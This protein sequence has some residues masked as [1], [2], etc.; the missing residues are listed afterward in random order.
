[1]GVATTYNAGA[2]ICSVNGSTVYN[3]PAPG[4]SISQTNKQL[5]TIQPHHR[6]PKLIHLGIVYLVCQLLSGCVNTSQPSP[7][8][9]SADPAQM[10]IRALLLPAGEP[11]AQAL[12][13]AATAAPATER[14]RLEL[15]A[16]EQW[17]Q[18]GRIETASALVNRLDF[19]TDSDSWLLRRQMLVAQ[20][21]LI[22]D[23]LIGA[24][25]ALNFINQLSVSPQERA[26]ALQLLNSF[27]RSALSF[28]SL[29]ATL[30]TE[31][32]L[33]SSVAQQRQLQS[34]LLAELLR[35]PRS[36]LDTSINDNFGLDAR[37]W[38]E[39]IQAARSQL[40]PLERSALLNE[41]QRRY[42]TVQVDPELLA[43]L[44]D[45]NPMASELP[46]KIALLLPYTGKLANAGKAL[47]DGIMAAYFASPYAMA[48][49]EL[50]SY[51]TGNATDVAEIYQRAVSEG[52]QLIIGPLR[53]QDI[54]LLVDQQ[55]VTVPTLA[56]NQIAHGGGITPPPALIQFGLSPED[57]IQQLARLAWTLGHRRAASFYPDT[58]LGHR[59][60]LAFEKSWQTLGGTL[61][62]DQTYPPDTQDFSDQ[63]EPL[64]G[65]DHSQRRHRQLETAL[66][67]PLQFTPR[68]R[69]DIDFL[70]LVAF[71]SQ[72]RAI[73]PQFRFHQAD[74]LPLFATSHLYSGAPDKEKDKDLNQIRLCDT[75]H[76]FNKSP[77]QPLPRIYALGMDAFGVLA[78]LPSLQTSALKRYD[79]ATGKLQIGPAGRIHAQLACGYFRQGMPESIA[80]WQ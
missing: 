77:H 65:L 50:R 52:A 79:G 46:S 59:L 67:L 63:I 13:T 74:D 53:K 19:A 22:Q 32:T 45:S 29:V 61:A 12:L 39:L 16:A 43:Q 64:L 51:D 71:P 80:E 8:L 15:E 30:A 73:R 31:L 20:I 23:D 48:S 14:R 6:T 28:P 34:Q 25:S 76:T 17:L 11:R 60:K 72:A 1:M 38:V 3:A 7:G 37:P 55:R 33:T 56:L 47:H 75:P 5:L 54:Q 41:W 36:A 49:V 18:A 9:E 4:D 44:R 57:E 42:P 35:F 58:E 2:T 27:R 40:S 66:Q 21:K 24:R 69:Q 70:F 68:R 62:V 10:R 26:A 78:Y